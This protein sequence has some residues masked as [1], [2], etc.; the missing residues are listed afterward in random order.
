MSGESNRE[1]AGVHRL[2]IGAQAL[3]RRQL[4]KLRVAV[5]AQIELSGEFIF[6]HVREFIV[7][8]GESGGW[9]L[10]VVIFNA[11]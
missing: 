4:G 7:T 10:I 6:R 1:M 11:D 2:E 9:D 8:Q 5:R 3:L